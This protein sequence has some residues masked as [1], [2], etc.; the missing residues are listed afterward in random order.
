MGLPIAGNSVQNL[1]W[2]FAARAESVRA[3]H[4]LLLKKKWV[5]AQYKLA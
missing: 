1:V 4:R 3:S 2:A 5:V